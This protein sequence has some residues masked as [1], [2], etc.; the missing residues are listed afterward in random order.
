MI[1]VIGG[2]RFSGLMEGGDSI[3]DSIFD[4]EKFE[5][6]ED[7]EML[8]VEDGEL[9]EQ[10]VSN[11]GQSSGGDTTLTSQESENKNRRRKN[12]KK[13]K[14]KRGSNSGPN[15]TDINRFV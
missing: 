7:V 15:V 12:K 3:L 4:D 13:Q 8:D 14:R 9:V 10:N 2:C 1:V 11:V 6:V 5:D